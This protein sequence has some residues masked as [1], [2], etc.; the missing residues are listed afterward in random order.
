MGQ[1]T[2][3]V[4]YLLNFSQRWLILVFTLQQFE[5]I[6]NKDLDIPQLQRYHTTSTGNITQACTPRS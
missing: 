3:T 5:L 1:R 6:L 2:Y 4:Q